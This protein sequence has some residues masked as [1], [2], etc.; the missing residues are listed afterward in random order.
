MSQNQLTITDP[1]NRQLI[2]PSSQESTIV[3]RFTEASRAIVPSV[4]VSLAKRIIRA[5][6][7]QVLCLAAH[8][9]VPL[10]DDELASVSDLAVKLSDGTNVRLSLSFFNDQSVGCIPVSQPQII[11]LN[12]STY[13]PNR[14]E[15]LREEPKLGLVLIATTLIAMA[16]L[17]SVLN[18]P[19]SPLHWQPAFKSAAFQSVAARTSKA[20]IKTI[21]ASP[22]PATLK[23]KPAKFEPE[24]G[25]SATR[26]ES[27]P[28]SKHAT[29][30]ETQ[31]LT[32]KT[33][34]PKAHQLKSERVFIPPPPNTPTLGHIKN[35]FVPPPPPMTYVFP[36][37]SGLLPIDPLQGLASA[38][39][40]TKPAG[41]PKSMATESPVDRKSA[42]G[43]K[44]TITA[45][46]R[47]EAK[48]T[49]NT[50]SAVSAQTT[51]NAKSA[52]D[53]S[54]SSSGPSDPQ[55]EH[56]PTGNN[57]T[58]STAPVPGDDGYPALERIVIPNQ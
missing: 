4:E 39:A 25:Q 13:D 22:G 17:Y 9:S 56:N 58:E 51:V 46:S 37:E 27:N 45:E 57:D 26:D 48:S 20:A 12:R 44:S 3:E 54:M 23:S 50:K 53:S 52:S 19:F 7:N 30:R 35:M 15:V 55:S 32:A 10:N 31:S 24:S 38:S 28:S 47:A 49:V 34:V 6:S 8:T 11:P 5:G 29:G 18:G 42:V 33:K 16:G 1:P 14:Y 36:A 41:N 21:A 43:A 40:K 2:D